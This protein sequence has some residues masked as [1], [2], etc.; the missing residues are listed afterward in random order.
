MKIIPIINTDFIGRYQRRGS[1]V[2]DT[3]TNKQ[4]MS[5]N[6]RVA[7]RLLDRLNKIGMLNGHIVDYNSKLSADQQA[8]LLSII[9]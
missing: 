1:K 4:Y 7:Q 3:L 9:V 5:N 8:Q 6:D 2:I